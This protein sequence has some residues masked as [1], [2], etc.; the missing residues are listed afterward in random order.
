MKI[1][2]NFK[3]NKTPTQTKE[4]FIDFLSGKRLDR[5]E[6]TFALPYTSIAVGKFMTEGTGIKIGAQN[7]SDEEEGNNTGEISGAMLK[8]SGVSSVIIGHNDRKT[9][10]KEN[11]KSI[12]KKIKI[13]LK[14]ALGIVLCVGE[15]ATERNTLKAYQT[16]KE[17]IEE[18]LKGLYENELENI[19]I[20]YE[21]V[22]AIGTGQSPTVKEIE[23][24]VKAIRKVIS[25]DFSE[26]AGKNISVIYGGSVNAKNIGPI[27]K[28][29][30][31]SGVLIGSSALDATAL[32]KIIESV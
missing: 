8:D 21:P 32:K 14:N 22:W 19:S 9:K 6:L 12:N 1:F 27:S 3:M 30:S 13:A 2:I 10:F 11:S 15:N 25:N 26:Y 5:N 31:L 7:M 17:Q 18:A 24:A 16:L 20:A 28:I 29:P 23:G 4:Y